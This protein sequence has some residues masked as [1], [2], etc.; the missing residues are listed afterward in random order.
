MNLEPD[1]SEFIAYLKAHDGRTGRSV[2]GE[3]ATSM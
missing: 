3:A 1:F 2:V